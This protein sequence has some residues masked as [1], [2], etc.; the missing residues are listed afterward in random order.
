MLDLVAVTVLLAVFSIGQYR[1]DGGTFGFH[2][3][4]IYN[5]TSSDK[6]DICVLDIEIQ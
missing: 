4:C 5:S 1:L 3:L 2:D 6:Q